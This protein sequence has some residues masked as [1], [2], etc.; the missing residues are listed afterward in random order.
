MGWALLTTADASP[1][2]RIETVAGGFATGGGIAALEAQLVSVE[3]VA[4]DPAGNIFLADAGDHRVLKVDLAGRMHTAAGTGAAGFSGDGGPGTHARLNSPY[5]LAADS[6]GNL[7]IADYR[8]GRVRRV[9]PSGNI[10]TVAGG[11]IA[12]VSALGS[13]PLSA[14]LKGPRNLALD[15]LGNLYISDYDAGAIY[16][17][18][19]DGRLY[20]FATGLSRP[21]GIAADAAGAVCVAESAGRAVRRIFGAQSEIFVAGLHTPAGLALDAR[22]NL[23]IADPG[24]GR[25]VMRPPSGPL[26]VVGPAARDVAVAFSGDVYLAAGTRIQRLNAGGQLEFVAGSA[27][28]GASGMAAPGARIETPIGVAVDALGQIYIAEERAHRVRRVDLNGRLQLVAGTG[29]PGGGGD[30]AQSVFAQLHDPV[31]VAIHPAGGLRIAEYEP[32]RVRGVASS[33]IAFTHL[34]AGRVRQP[35]GM[36]FDPAGNLYIVDAG[37]RRILRVAADGSEKILGDGAFLGPAAVALGRNADLYVA[38]AGGNVIRRLLPSGAIET[39]AGTGAAGFAGDGGPATM[40]QLSGP[41]G[42]AVDSSGALWIADTFNHRVRRVD[43]QGVITTVSGTGTAGFAGDGGDAAAA[44]LDTPASIA[45]APDG[46]VVVADLGNQRIRRLVPDANAASGPITP[47]AEIR[48]EATVVH[49]ATRR[50]QPV[51]PGQWIAIL[52]PPAGDLD[53]R[54]DGRPAVILVMNALEVVLLVP[55]TA[56]GKL[57]VEALRGGEPAVRR[58]IEVVAAAPGLFSSAEGEVLA[59]LSGQMTGTRARPAGRGSILTFYATGQGVNLSPVRFTVGGSPVDI[60]FAGPAPELPGV[61]QINARMPGLF[62]APGTY[63]AVLW[64]GDAP[65]PAGIVITLD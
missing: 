34:M 36:V 40:A 6:R 16:R 25:V 11:G 7:Y 19:I 23:F 14:K 62:T 27:Q 4:T 45:I 53:W 39:V 48:R 5:G 33:G 20:P 32:G 3:G 54:I 8:N 29:S 55:E 52:D 58:E 24:Q 37:N 31:A 15:A 26:I 41:T 59:S 57:A 44:H 43:A 49:A 42:V 64:I 2:F 18:G 9:A 22:G 56:A 51:A 17:L 10:T 28:P 30:G 65:S 61:M 35:R 21:A 63:E 38:D 13:D 1:R 46:S 47:P 50:Q 60:L 12:G